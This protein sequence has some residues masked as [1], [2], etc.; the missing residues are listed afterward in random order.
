MMLLESRIPFEVVSERE[1]HRLPDYELVILPMFAAMS[2]QQAEQIRDY[3]AQGGKILATG[4]TSLYTEEGVLLGD[5]QLSDVFGVS[6]T[7]VQPGKVYVNDYGSGRSVFFYS[8][9]AGW[10]FTPELDYFWSAEPWEG[11]A[12]DPTGAEQ[13]G[14]KGAQLLRR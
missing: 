8:W 13:A 6:Y 11:G 10:A 14:L 2:P 5:F 12:P 3:V 4:P 1:L 7:G 9:E